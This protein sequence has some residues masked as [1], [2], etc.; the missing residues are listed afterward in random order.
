[1]SLPGLLIGFVRQR[2]NESTVNAKVS[3]RIVELLIWS[4]YRCR[5][6]V[7]TLSAL[8]STPHPWKCFGDMAEGAGFGPAV[9]V[10]RR[11]LSRRVH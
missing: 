11:P 4:V 8:A 6:V 3:G 2:T 5:A 10:A 9:G 1:M 7:E